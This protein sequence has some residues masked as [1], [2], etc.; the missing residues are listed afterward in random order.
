VDRPEE[1][2]GA[3]VS[4]ARL[5]IDWQVAGY[6]VLIGAG[7]ALLAS[8]LIHAPA[9]AGALSVL[10]GAVLGGALGFLL[11][12]P[13]K[14]DLTRIGIYAALLAR[15]QYNAPP[16]EE[17]TGELL[18][19][20][21]QLQQMAQAWSGQVEALQ[22]L[23]DERAHFA[24]RTERLAVLEERQR[25]ARELHDTV[26]QELFGLAMLVAATRNL[27]P[28]DEV[29]VLARLRQVEDGARRAQA[30]MRGLIRALRPVELGDKTLK[31]ALGVLLRDVRERQ[32]IETT[33]LASGER[34]IPPGVEDALF[35]VAQEAVS[36][37]VRHGRPAHI[38]VAL[39]EEPGAVSLS[40]EDDGAGFQT[41]AVQ[42]HVGFSTMRERTAEIGA[43][44]SIRSQPGSGTRVVVRAPFHAVG[45]DPGLDGGGDES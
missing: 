27:V 20:A 7:A 33:L 16:V 34:E 5:G 1:R 19:L 43:R 44:L 41:T 39:T 13:L 26:S 2:R 12:R 11:A 38:T 24:D 21:R 10:L 4:A 42:D 30:T 9:A 45:G 40:V 35:R 28:G 17:G 37:A 32:A 15:G 6:G 14:R 18:Y 23:A 22:R 29:E 3:E 31:D 8:F 36:N 25:L